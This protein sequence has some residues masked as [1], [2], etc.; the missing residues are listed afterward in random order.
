MGQ[1]TLSRRAWALATLLLAIVAV[2]FAVVGA[3]SAFPAGLSVLAC[4]LAAVWSAWYGVCRRR[5]LRT[6]G[7]AAAVVLVAGAL[8]LIIVEGRLLDNLLVLAA[9]AG[10]LATAR[11]AF[12]VHVELPAAE[13]PQHPVLFYNPLSGGGKAERFNL[14]EEARRRGI[15]PVQLHRGDDLAALVR[16]AVADGADAL[17]MAGGDGSQAIVAMIAADLDLPYACIPAGTRNHF[18]LDLGVDRSDVVGALDALVSGGERRVD[19]AEVNGRVFVNNVSLGLYAEAVQRPGYRGA[20]LHTLLD[21]VPDVLGPDA[22]V[23][24]LRWEGPLGMESAA[25]ILVSNN[26]YRLG[27]ALGSGTRPQLDTGRLGVTVLVPMTSGR[28]GSVSHRLAM[29]QWTVREFEVEAD[30]LVPVGLDG[31]ALELAPPLRFRIRPGALRV[32]IAPQHPGASPSALEPE[33]A[34][35]TIGTVAGFALR[36]RPR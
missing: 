14:A 32:R 36:G 10:V 24:R 29:H 8:A 9:V 31:E 3:V 28:D 5:F 33:T 27:R 17:A 18:A 35:Q 12:R 11:M 21:T 19:L 1:S 4:L 25:A 15:E 16:R 20:K 30:G 23:P 22:R 34:W 7:L 26:P 6:A 2:T 13:R